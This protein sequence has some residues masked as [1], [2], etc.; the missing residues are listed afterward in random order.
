MVEWFTPNGETVS[1]IARPLWWFDV[2]FVGPVGVHVLT[3][4]ARWLE[5]HDLIQYVQLLEH[6]HA[7]L[8]PKEMRRHRWTRERRSVE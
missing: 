6:A 3:I 4:Q 1:D 5:F 2:R 7:E 8:A